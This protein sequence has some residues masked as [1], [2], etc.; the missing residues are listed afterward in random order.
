[1]KT[2]IIAAFLAF[3]LSGCIKDVLDVA[4]LDRISD[5]DVFKSEPLSVTYLAALY[6][7]IPIGFPTQVS[8]AHLTDEASVPYSVPG[9]VSG[10]GNHALTLNTGMYTYIRKANYFLSRIKTSALTADQIKSLSA[11]CRFIRAYYY[12]DLVKKYGGMPIITEVQY[13]ADGI[14]KLQVSRNK[15]DEVYEFILAELNEAAKDLPD[16]RDAANANRATKWTALALKSRAMLYA[17]SIAKYGTVQLDGLVGIPAE[18]MVK[19]YTESFN[20]S[21]AIIEGKKYAL[22]DKLYNPVSKVG[23][24]ATNYQNIFLD[25]GNKEIIFQKAYSNP[26]KTHNYDGFNYPESFR[27]G[28]YGNSLSVTLE[29]VESYEYI[30]G[31]PGI[32][33]IGNGTKEYASPDELFKNKDPRFEGTILRPGSILHGKTVQI[34][35]GIYD[36]TGKLYST[37]NTPF[38]LDKSVMQVGKDGPYIIGDVGKTGFYIKKYMNNAPVPENKSDQNYIDFRYAEILL[39]YTEAAFEA[40]INKAEALDAI[41]QVRNRA[42]IKLLNATELTID[43]IRNE[44]KVE[45]AFEDH[46]FWDMR[47]WRI[48]TIVLAN[49]FIHGLWPYLK[50]NNGTYKY[51]FQSVSGSPIDQGRTR[52]FV[53]RDYYSNLAGYIS[54]NKNIVN[55]PGWN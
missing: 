7:N 28:Q 6:N 44:R 9:P 32:L 49:T 42:G 41:N 23:N 30:D 16:T 24:P 1:M 25:K 17:G 21:K 55:N 46:R 14:D 40:N 35:R 54:T 38:D 51:I 5:E 53:E 47:R 20:A 18:K 27:V 10:Y 19:Y 33:D 45:L 29:M 8:L 37:F 26:D 11:E 2:R 12:F 34:Y 36:E 3:F 13:I 43:K 39:N 31:S 48:G 50:Y 4:P 52:N 15:E 22:Y